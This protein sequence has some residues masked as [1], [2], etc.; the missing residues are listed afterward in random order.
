MLDVRGYRARGRGNGAGVPK[1]RAMATLEDTAP[2][3]LAWLER[4]IARLVAHRQE[5]REAG[6]DIG[7]LEANRRELVSAQKALSG[8]L[9]ER[10]VR[11]AA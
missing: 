8:L 11:H 4:R 3:S 5:L 6:A 9:I 7:R 10:Y 2:D 1:P